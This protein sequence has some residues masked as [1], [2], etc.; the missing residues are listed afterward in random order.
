MGT[1][2][3]GDDDDV[4][5]VTRQQSGLSDSHDSRRTMVSGPRQEGTDRVNLFTD[6]FRCLNLVGLKFQLV[7]K[8]LENVNMGESATFVTYVMLKHIPCNDFGTQ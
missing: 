1:C 3:R 2:Q 4:G 5:E 6:V 7:T 8:F